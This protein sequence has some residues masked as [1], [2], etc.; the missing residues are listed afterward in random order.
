M[1][2]RGLLTGLLVSGLMVAGSLVAM[3]AT[4][5]PTPVPLSPSL[6]SQLLSATSGQ[7]PVM[8]HG[9][10]LADAERA[11][12][13]TGMQLVTTYRKIGVVVARGTKQQ[14]KAAR[15]Q[16]G[17]TYLEGDQP[18]TVYAASSQLATRGVEA[19]QTLVGANGAA[20]EGTGVS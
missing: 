13:A 12:A 10:T 6:V 17:V 2:R 15:T 18:I 11:V 9:A 7:I 4:A 3:P 8:V 14:V 5:Q 1:S 19:H 20:L 16:P